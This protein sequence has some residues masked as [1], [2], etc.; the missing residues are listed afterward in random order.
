MKSKSIPAS[1]VYC[2]IAFV[3][4]ALCVPVS[5]N[6]QEVR[7]KITGRVLDPNNAAMPGASVKVT[8]AAR[9]TTVSLTTNDEGLFQ[10]NYLLSG[11]Y[12]V[13]VEIAGF[14]RYIQDGVLL[15]INENRNL[16][17]VLEVGGTQ[18]TVTVTAEAADLNTADANLGQTIDQKRMA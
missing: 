16:D 10:A 11:A 17:I 6:A 9:G 1:Y 5:L 15:Q 2:A 12:Q 8:D 4:L 7:G 14:K 18:E 3:L 13:V